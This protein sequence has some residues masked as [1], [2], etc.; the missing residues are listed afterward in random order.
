MID[1]PHKGRSFDYGSPLPAVLVIA[2]PGPRY[3]DYEQ[4]ERVSYY[5]HSRRCKCLARVLP[6]V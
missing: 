2:E 4:C 6:P 3:H 5:R 1:G